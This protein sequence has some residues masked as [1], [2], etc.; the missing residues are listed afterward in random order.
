MRSKEVTAG[1]NYHIQQDLEIGTWNVL[2]LYRAGHVQ[3][4]EENRVVKREFEM[5]IEG[6]RKQGRPK[7]RWKDC[8]TLDA[9]SIGERNWMRSAM[10]SDGWK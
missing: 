1:W 9:R 7:T 8:V 5:T 2:S 10:D 4:M 6:R 3:R